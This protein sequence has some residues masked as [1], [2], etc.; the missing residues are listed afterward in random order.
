MGTTTDAAAFQQGAL[1]AISL[2]F[3]RFPPRFP[4]PNLAAGGVNAADDIFMVGRFVD[5]D[6][7]ETD[8][9]SVRFGHIS[10]IDAQI[11]QSTNYRGRSIIVDMHSR[12]GYSG[13]PVF[14]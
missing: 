12:T 4:S 5:Y 8:V 11:R 3:S 1:S 6:G 9:L 7:V 14:V 10:I 2:A 13:S